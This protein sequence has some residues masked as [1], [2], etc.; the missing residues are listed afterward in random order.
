MVD[1]AGLGRFDIRTLSG[2]DQAI[3]FRGRH[4]RDLDETV[5][6][7]C[8]FR[9][10]DCDFQSTDNRDTSEPCGGY[11]VLALLRM[12]GIDVVA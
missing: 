8:A 10:E 9:A 7:R 11:R 6:A 4:D 3:D 1:L 5:C 12:A 2:L